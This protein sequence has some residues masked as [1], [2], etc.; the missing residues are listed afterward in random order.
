MHRLDPQSQAHNEIVQSHWSQGQLPQ[1]SG[2][3]LG[4]GRLVVMNESS[5]MAEGRMHCHVSP[6]CESSVSSFVQFSG[7]F[8]E[9][10]RTT[11]PLQLNDGM[12]AICGEGEMG[13]EGFVAV[14]A[15]K[16]LVWAAL[17]ST[18]N[19]FYKL[20]LGDSGNL[21]ATSTHELHWQFPILSPWE[22]RV[23]PPID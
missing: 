12:C 5:Y 13:N 4:D 8:I 10:T 2:I 1:F 20:S 15:G 17:F 3:T 9:I 19:P 11:P 21:I 23:S 6:I 16:V 18:S 7:E 22:A 14:I